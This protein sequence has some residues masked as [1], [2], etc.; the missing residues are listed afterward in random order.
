M[1][2]PETKCDGLDNDCNG[3]ADDT[4]PTKG[5]ACTKGLGVCT[6]TGQLI[7]NPAEDGLL[8]N[9]AEPG[10]GTA[11]LCN[12]LDDDCDGMLDEDAPDTWVPIQT[13]RQLGD[14]CV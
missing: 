5:D 4:F 6:T 13:T 14:V 7:C 3:R 10:T 9:A 8:C 2:I 12:G 11:E 1:I